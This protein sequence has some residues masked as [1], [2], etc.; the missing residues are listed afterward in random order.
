MLPELFVKSIIF[1]GCVLFELFSE[2]VYYTLRV[3]VDGSIVIVN[4]RV[5]GWC[6]CFCFFTS[7]KK[8]KTNVTFRCR[9]KVLIF[10]LHMTLIFHVLKHFEIVFLRVGSYSKI[11]DQFPW[12]CFLIFRYNVIF[13]HLS[14]GPSLL[15]SIQ[16]VCI[17]YNYSGERYL[18]QN[19]SISPV[20]ILCHAGSCKFCS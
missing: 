4:F 12:A 18:L 5:Y 14:G 19:Y 2:C 11:S 20:V 16:D 6:L 9:V 3:V 17:G 8:N 15:L 13:V 7:S 10:L 1:R